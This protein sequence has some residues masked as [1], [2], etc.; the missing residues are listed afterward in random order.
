MLLLMLVQIAG[1]YGQLAARKIM[2]K[3]APLITGSILHGEY[4][5][6][7]ECRGKFYVCC[8]D[9]GTYLVC[10]YSFKEFL[11][12]NVRL[13]LELLLLDVL[14]LLSLWCCCNCG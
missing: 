4:F 7:R 8:G 10:D 6:S 14:L 9:G 5:M 13:L 11:L 2:L 1:L 12:P 3:F